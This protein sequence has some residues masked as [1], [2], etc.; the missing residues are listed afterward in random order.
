VYEELSGAEGRRVF[1]R[2]E[3]FDAARLFG[4]IVPQVEINHGGYRLNDLSIGGLAIL[5]GRATEFTCEVGAQVPIRLRLGGTVLHEGR[6]RICRIDPTPLGEKVALHLTDSYF[7]IP[8]IVAQSKEASLRREL[9]GWLGAGPE[10]VE[11]EYRQ[12]C[13]DVLHLLRRYRFAIEKFGAPANESSD[14]A[15]SACTADVLSLCEERIL[16]QCRAL[17]RRGNELV[18]PLMDDPEA[19]DATKRFTELIVTPEFLAGPIWRRCYDKPLGY[20]GDYQVMNYVYSRQPEGE[21]PY[22]RLL[23]RIG[24]DGMESIA[25]RMV[26][27]QQVIARTVTER[28]GSEPVR[29]ASLACGPAQEVV[30]YL[31]LRSLPRPVHFTLIDQDCHALSHAYHQTYPEVVRLKGRG[32]VECLHTSFSQLLKTNHLF[33]RIGPQDLI[34]AVGLLDY[35]GERA[36]RSLVAGLYERLTPGGRLVVG[37]VKDARNGFLWPAEFVCDWSLVY[38]NEDEM[39]R[40]A[41]NIDS[42]LVEVRTDSSS[43]VCFLH[44]SKP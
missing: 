33:Q 23:H 16:P 43:Q 13:I 6:G 12:H 29:I 28:P 26:T 44:L 3:R 42:P 5:A 37:N 18:R 24:L 32:R 14:E 2:A 30:N 22:T 11:P 38:R 15:N 7:D 17:W 19:L 41:D 31:R 21:T 20:P 27:M 34:Y 10:R 1:Y 4:G 25:A 35:L 8:R 39:R 36:A 40:L 9:D